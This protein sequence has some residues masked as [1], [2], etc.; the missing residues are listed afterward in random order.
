MRRSAPS[1][2]DSSADTAPPVSEDESPRAPD[3]R[4]VLPALGAWAGAIVALELPW[5]SW[6]VPLLVAG[7]TAWRLGAVLVVLVTVVAGV[8][9]TAAELRAAGHGSSL[10]AEAAARNAAV[11]LELS[12]TTDPRVRPGRFGDVVIVRGRATSLEWRGETY[13]VAA[14]VLILGR[15]DWP[16]VE[17]GSSIS[18]TGR[19]ASARS[20][21]LAATVTVSRPPEVLAAPT[22][23]LRSAGQVRASIREALAPAGPASRELVPALVVG[24]DQG[25]PAETTAAFQVSGLT[26]LTA[27]S[28]TNLTLVV[29]FLL[30][31]ARW[32]GWRGRAL[33]LLGLLGVIGF[34][35]LA[36][37]EPSVVRAAA[38]GT[39]ALLCWSTDGRSRGVRALSGGV[40]VLLLVNPW[41][42]LSVGF[43]LSVCAT[44]GILVL[45]PPLRDALS[46]WLPRPVAEAIAV[47]VAAQVACTPLVAVVS[48]QVS[49]VAVAA[50]LLV[51]PAVAPATVLGLIGGMVHLVWPWGG[52]ML[53]RGAGWCADWIIVVA[54]RSAALPNAAFAWSTGVIG[55]SVLILACLAVVMWGPGIAASPALTTAVVVLLAAAM[56]RPLPSFGWP[57]AGWVMVA[58]DVG[59]GDALVLRTGPGSAVVVDVG[60]DA[61]A[62]DRCLK[63]LGVTQVPVVILSHFHDDHVGGLP[64]VMRG[65]AVGEIVGPGFAYPA[66][67]VAGVLEQAGDVPVRTVAPPQVR[68]VGE[69]VWQ[70]VGPLRIPSAAQAEVS[71]AAN[72]ASLVLL[73][74]VEGIRILL[75]GDI[76]PDGQRALARSLPGLRVDVVKVPHHGSRNQDVEFL[77]GL[78]A[79]LAVLSVGRDNEYGHPAPQTLQVLRSAGMVVARTDLH[80][81]IAVVVS[82]GAIR[83]VER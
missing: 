43:A 44:A 56:L 60:P 19:L 73:V 81:D 83:L 24:D 12:L 20:S 47:P 31:V 18:V 76:E 8:T 30:L 4:L 40:L 37:P 17:L 7:L 68:R 49:L 16:D 82:D 69:I 67:N 78:G 35:I 75:T 54:E 21:D 10:V 58:C 71:A 39:V 34:V 48:G 2:A 55:L 57:P 32:L 11:T 66:P 64:G 77:S 15:G 80:G 70:V 6:S 5:W 36:R 53:G 46:G 13:R 63:R 72:N 41:L 14:P 51:A 52:R 9:G 28:G 79:A 27:V 3:L 45:S 33:V 29:G 23:L 59:Q 1:A 42:A 22:A 25:L 61:G 50:N 74:E 62:V 38:M 65:R 26:H